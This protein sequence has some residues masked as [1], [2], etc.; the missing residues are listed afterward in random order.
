MVLVLDASV[1]LGWYFADEN[2]LSPGFVDR[3][4]EAPAVVPSHFEAEVV[5]GVLVGERRGR[6]HPRHVAAL[7]ELL[8]SMDLEI[9]GDGAADAVRTILP[10]ARAH[11]LT[12]YDALYLELAERRGL[13]LA[14]LDGDLS[15][16]ARSIGLEVMDPSGGGR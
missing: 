13:A 15:A 7:L 10:L 2:R 16:A 14:T 11:R 1:V 5:N 3:L 12:V 8:A 9:D 6:S 4:I